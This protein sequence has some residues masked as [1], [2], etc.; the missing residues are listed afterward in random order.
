M[1]YEPFKLYLLNS[2]NQVSRVIHYSKEG[3]GADDEELQQS[4]PSER[5]QVNIYKDDVIENVKFK[6]VSTLN[7][8]NI[9]NYYFF[10]KQNLTIDVR[11]LLNNNKSQDGYVSYNTFVSI[12]KNL[13]LEGIDYDVQN[14]YSI[15]YIN[16]KLGESMNVSINIPLGLD[17]HVYKHVYIVNPLENSLNYSYTDASEKNADLLFELGTI[18]ENTIYC[19]HVSEYFK[20]IQNNDMIS[21]EDTMKI[22]YKSLHSKNIFSNDK[23]ESYNESLVEK[24]EN[25]NK[26]I[27]SHFIFYEQYSLQEK[28]DISDK[29]KITKIEFNYKPKNEIIF[30]LEILFKKLQ[31]NK[32]MPFA[33]FNPGK[34]LENIYRLYCPDKDKYGNKLPLFSLKDIKKYKEKIKKEKSVSLILIDNKKRTTIFHV[35][36]Q[37]EIYCSF[38]NIDYEIGDMVGV[39]NYAANLLNKILSLFIKYFDPTSLVYQE[40]DDIQDENIEIIEIQY[41]A[42]LKQRRNKLDTKH[43]PGIFTKVSGASILNYKRVSNYDK[44][45]DIDATITKMLKINMDPDYI[46]EQ[47]ADMFFGGNKEES[48]EY[49]KRFLS[50]ISVSDHMKEDGV[51]KI[52][53]NFLHNPGFEIEFKDERNIVFDVKLVN[54][55]QYIHSIL[56]FLH[57]LFLIQSNTL[58]SEIID[59]HFGIESA[60]VDDIIVVNDNYKEE[61]FSES[62]NESNANNARINKMFDDFLRGDDGYD[63]EK[64]QEE[65]SQTSRGDAEEEEEP[66]P[67]KPVEAAEE[68]ENALSDNDSLESRSAYEE[69]EAEE[70]EEEPL[71]PTKEA[72]EEVEVENKPNENKEQSGDEDSEDE[73][74]SNNNSY[75]SQFGGGEKVKLKHSSK[76]SKRMT[77]YQPLLFKSEGNKGQY[78]SY[79]R[80]CPSQL[81]IKRQ[82][83]IITQ[84]EKAEIDEKYPGSYDKIIKYGTNPKKESF[85]YMCPKYWNFKEMAPVREEDVDPKHLIPEGAKEVDLDDGRY[86]Y[87]VTDKYTTPGFIQSKKNKHG[88][89]LPCCFGLKDGA[90][91]AEIIKQAEEQM[92]MI[93]DENIDDQEEVIKFLKKNNKQ[94]KKRV[95]HYQ[96]DGT[97]FP[98]PK[99][100]FGNLPLPIEEFLGLSHQS[101]ETGRRLYRAGIENNDKKSFMIALAYIMDP[102]TKDPI[103]FVINVIKEK[104]T[105]DNILNF[106]NGSIPLIFYDKKSVSKDDKK[107]R[108]LKIYAKYKKKGLR[109]ELSKL[110]NGYEHF[111]KY[112]EDDNEYI[113]YF[114]LWD[115]VSSGILFSDKKNSHIN[116]IILRNN[117]DDITQN[118]SIV[119]PSSSHSNFRYSEAN[120]TIFI[121]QKHDMFEPIVMPKE[122]LDKQRQHDGI[123]TREKIKQHL[124]SYTWIILE[125]IMLNISDKC[126]LTQQNKKHQYEY[127]DNISFKNVIDNNVIKDKYNIHKQILNFD[128]KV[129]A[130]LVSDKSNDSEQYYVPIAPSPR[131]DNYEFVFID[132]SYWRDYESTKKFLLDFY[133]D[134]D[135]QV[136]CEPVLKIIENSLVVGLLT[137]SNQFVKIDPPREIKDVQDNIKEYDEYSHFDVD[138]TLT[139]HGQVDSEREKL[140]KSLIVET[141]LY[142][143]YVNT[144]KHLLSKDLNQKMKIREILKNETFEEAYPQ[145]KTII[146]E[147]TS[148]NFTFVY[149]DDE[150]FLSLN[151]INLCHVSDEE[152]RDHCSVDDEKIKM[153]I[154]KKNLYT[155]EDNEE[156]YVSS[157]TFDLLKNEIVKYNVLDS[158]LNVFNISVSY[159]IS[160]TEIILLEKFLLKYFEKVGEK[161]SKY[162]LQGTF[163]DLKPQDLINYIESQEFEY[164]GKGKSVGEKEFEEKKEE[165]LEEKVVGEEEEAEEAE[166]E[167]DEKAVSEEESEA[168]EKQLDETTEDDS[169][170]L[171]TFDASELSTKSEEFRQQRSLNEITEMYN[172]AS[173]IRDESIVE[174]INNNALDEVEM[175]KDVQEMKMNDVV[176][177]H[178]PSETS[179]VHSGDILDEYTLNKMPESDVIINFPKKVKKLKLKVKNIKGVVDGSEVD[180]DNPEYNVGSLDREQSEKNIEIYKSFYNSECVAYKYTTQYWRGGKFPPRSKWL[181]FNKKM[182][183]CNFNLLIFILKMHNFNR[184]QSVT[185]DSIK[186]TLIKYYEDV[187]FNCKVTGKSD[188]K[189]QCLKMLEK[190]WKNEGKGFID[191]KNTSIET[192]IKNEGYILTN[193]DLLLY[194]YMKNIPI[195]IY[196]ESKGQVKMT[197]FKKNNEKRFYYLVYYSSRTNDFYLT[198]H[199]KK[200]RFDLDELGEQISKP[201]IDKA[202]E[203]FYSYLFSSF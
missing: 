58:D 80:M 66:P 71:Q 64:E 145:L 44:M 29:T 118:V 75:G 84:E 25:Y 168:E 40:F 55:F 120:D 81:G 89:F 151:N 36:G 153:L 180:V 148:E 171:P 24:Y 27:D 179:E 85:Y 43:F 173:S 161:R 87:K 193:V 20:Y 121:Y 30:P 191:L 165:E 140:T 1:N 126:S 169:G 53:K 8:T 160:K 101:N 129:V 45:S 154:P 15:E 33:K 110:I 167:E 112:L 189:K 50:S 190:K 37:G 83:I 147:I 12:L 68:N 150:M 131:D 106:H 78:T 199:A 115:I 107:Y 124:G 70:E 170:I 38:E 2:E 10:V 96:L 77:K 5:H 108:K 34:S 46:R 104:V 3:G 99:N 95:V 109:E 90:K 201:L 13:N 128:N 133:N 31:C 146:D 63:N 114:Y 82:P 182:N 157:L 198:T 100:R 136:K 119:C 200:L 57:N 156:K 127:E 69:S 197:N 94:E 35:N 138:K 39:T 42:H 175:D 41:S 76:L 192:I 54:H 134:S 155:K 92:K 48:H 22:Y 186:T 59:A 130:I 203:D 178:A 183:K 143:T 181:T 149:N 79:S 19:L 177:G 88:Y 166:A 51:K 194:A 62:N 60:N 174:Q 74:E 162:V 102:T 49:F 14:E 98:L 91:Q 23:I 132:D 122:M 67:S 86:I 7:D 4:I 142:N 21:M 195:V 202:H 28:Y 172:K 137:S 184:F 123:L 11:Q 185:I 105:L 16:E 61:V 65:P 52:F 72:E 159:T 73:F 158:L 116:L 93:E 6:L 144:I 152:N 176:E 32:S 18:E 17:Y 97:K 113:D 117:E 163:E 56:L 187:I 47:C 188:M 125:S 141:E 196:Y 103:G 26:L 164:D 9:E 135:K 111:M 139:Q